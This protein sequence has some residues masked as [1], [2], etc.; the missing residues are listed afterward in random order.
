MN[1]KSKPF[2]LTSSNNKERSGNHESSNKINS[3][4][5]D[6]GKS[7]DDK[8]TYKEIVNKNN[9]N[10]DD[11]G[12]HK[13]IVIKD[14]KGKPKESLIKDNSNKSKESL[15]KDNSSKSKES[16]I[17][18]IFN[19]S[20]DNLV[21]VNKPID[22]YAELCDLLEE[23]Q[24]NNEECPIYRISFLM[25]EVNYKYCPLYRF[26]P[27]AFYL[28]L[29]NL[30]YCEAPDKDFIIDLPHI[31][32]DAIT[33][34]DVMWKVF[35]SNVSIL[36]NISKELYIE[37]VT[38]TRRLI[39]AYQVG[40]IDHRLEHAITTI[41]RLIRY[42]NK[43]ENKE[44][45]K[46]WLSKFEQEC[47]QPTEDWKKHHIHIKSL[48][49]IPPGLPDN[50]EQNIFHWNRQLI[51]E[52]IFDQYLCSKGDGYETKI[53]LDVTEF[54]GDGYHNQKLYEMKK[55]RVNQLVFSHMTDD[56]FNK[57][58]LL[59]KYYST[60]MFNLWRC[61]DIDKLKFL[62]INNE[63]QKTGTP[64]TVSDDRVQKRIAEFM[65]FKLTDLIT[66]YKK[67]EVCNYAYGFFLL[68]D[69]V[70]INLNK[71]S[72]QE[73]K[74]WYLHMIIE[75]LST[76]GFDIKFK[77]F[78]QG[79][80]MH[81]EEEDAMIKY[82]KNKL[83]ECQNKVKQGIPIVSSFSYSTPIVTPIRLSINKENRK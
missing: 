74:T 58:H 7:K 1:P 56:D 9:S 78:L 30:P 16:L 6:K 55:S 20:K 63:N 2:V 54:I 43:P 62:C 79:C 4:R 68:R 5:D 18:D 66:I 48:D 35:I 57:L 10:K 70:N 41:Q 27:K 65:Y 33:G 13:E 36:E 61:E 47:H 19:K 42:R 40:F 39:D 64:A 81:Q 67:L 17:K 76:T 59:I 26:C 45:P 50:A 37:K 60:S 11:K 14:D 8:V 80:E 51:P 77:D 75:D 72:I 23:Y 73:L 12:K 3:N 31:M 32:K 28:Y 44:L 71:L 52:F 83:D 69:F 25:K 82:I 29:I 49:D 34:S 22:E 38:D 53:Y 24:I 15:I 21:I 46:D